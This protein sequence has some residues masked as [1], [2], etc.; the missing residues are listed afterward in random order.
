MGEV[1]SPGP[2]LHWSQPTQEGGALAS[3]ELRLRGTAGPGVAAAL[4]EFDV[5]VERDSTIVIAELPDQAALHGLLDRIRD[6]GIEIV[7]LRQIDTRRNA[8]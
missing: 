8:S 5:H 2:T 1:K 7:E 3:Y 6:L 4:G